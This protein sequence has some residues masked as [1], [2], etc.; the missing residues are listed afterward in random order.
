MTIPALV[1]SSSVMSEVLFLTLLLPFLVRAEYVAEGAG[2]GQAA[3]LGVGAGLLFYVRA[4]AIV[5]I[6]AI[7]IVYLIGRRRREAAAVTLAGMLL[8]FP[9][10]HSTAM[11]WSGPTAA[12]VF[13]QGDNP[14]VS[15]DQRPRE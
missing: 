2:A 7:A 4:Q 5:L 9:W 12:T 14:R 8:I 13:R 10:F 3:L 1:L 11:R 15:H 6:P